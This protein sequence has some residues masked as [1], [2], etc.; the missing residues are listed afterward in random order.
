MPDDPIA[1]LERELVG[2]ARRRAHLA[3]A[4][5][6]GRSAPRRRGSLGGFA[7][8]VLAGLAAVVGLGALVSLRGHA[9]LRPAP[10]AATIPGRQQLIDI[11]GVLRRPQTSADLHAP[12]LQHPARFGAGVPDMSLVRRAAVTPWG[13]AVYLIPVKPPTGARATEGINLFVG[14]GGE[15]CATS[16][17]IQAYGELA[18]DRAGRSFAG[19]S[20]QARLA[21]IVPDGVVRVEFVF[22]R[23]PDPVDLGGPIYR[24]ELV[25]AARVHDNLAAVQVDRECCGGDVPMIWQGAD[26]RVIKQIGNVGAAERVVAPPQPAPETAFSRAAERDPSTPN[27]VWVTPTA[28]GPRTAFSVHFRLTGADYRYEITGT[29]FRRT[30]SRAEEAAAPATSADTSG[31]TG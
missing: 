25:V 16:A 11:L 1:A 5:G 7:V 23:Q 19:G 4:A 26:G 14:S 3:S 31:A 18:I 30:P 20:T 29:P 17:D 28:G 2:A 12:L 15:C 22:P 24:G 21:V 8:V 13:A 27:R 9:P 10:P 6:T